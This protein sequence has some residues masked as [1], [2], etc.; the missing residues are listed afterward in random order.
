[1]VVIKVYPIREH[2]SITR[3]FLEADV[4]I[5]WTAIA[6]SKCRDTNTIRLLNIPAITSLVFVEDTIQ[7]DLN[8]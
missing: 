2:P 6:P 3:C 8:R 1:M 7:T 4:A 5:E